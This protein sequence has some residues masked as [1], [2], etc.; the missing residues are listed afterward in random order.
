[1]G[2]RGFVSCECTIGFT[3]EQ[4]EFLEDAVRAGSFGSFADGVRALVTLG[5]HCWDDFGKIKAF[6]CKN[7]ASKMPDVG[8][9]KVLFSMPCPVVGCNEVFSGDESDNML[10]AYIM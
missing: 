2:R 6:L 8:G 10:E 9:S 3:K 4:C 7:C 1:M 5:V